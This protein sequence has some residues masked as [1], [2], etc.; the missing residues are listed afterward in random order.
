[1]LVPLQHAKPRLLKGFLQAIITIFAGQDPD[2]G[3][4]PRKILDF[5]T[6]EERS[7]EEMAA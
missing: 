2:I 4:Y 7:I 3:R 1:M 5:Q 6:A